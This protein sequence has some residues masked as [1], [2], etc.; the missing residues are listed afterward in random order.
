MW[1]LRSKKLEEIDELG[2]KEVTK[3]NLR[4]SLKWLV[5]SIQTDEANQQDPCGEQLWIYITVKL[6]FYGCFFLIFFTSV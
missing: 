5:V 3:R 2:Y 4:Y 6:E 1:V